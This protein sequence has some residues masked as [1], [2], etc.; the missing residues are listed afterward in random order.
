M[1]SLPG[2]AFG[3]GVGTAADPRYLMFQ[4]F[5]AG[6]GFTTEPDS[7]IIDALPSPD[8]LPSQSREILDA[9]GTRGD[10]GHRLG[11]M[12]GPLV[13][14]YTDAQMRTLIERTFA[15][16]IDEHVAVG[17]HIDDS[18]FWM[19][20]RDLWSDPANVEWL[21]WQ[22][23]PN[24]GQYLD[25]GG[26]PWRLAPQAC[27]NSPAMLKEAR[28]VAGMVIGPAIAAGLAKLR[29]TGDEAL[30]AGVIVG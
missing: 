11:V 25:W 21:D 20:R 4:L 15:I 29:Q 24:G 27:F 7:H 5:T 6:P 30:F 8:M 3:Q 16:A 18:K 14:D 9:V 2:A 1:A 26:G 23:T 28:R 12:I 10:A 19:K 13:L 17:L 22:G